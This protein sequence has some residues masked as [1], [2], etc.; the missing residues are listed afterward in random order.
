MEG[1]IKQIAKECM[2]CGSCM[3]GETRRTCAW[4]CIIP[5]I[6]PSTAQSSFVHRAGML[7]LIFESIEEKDIDIIFEKYL[8]AMLLS[9]LWT[10]DCLG[11]IFTVLYIAQ[12]RCS[13]RMHDAS[14]VEPRGEV[15]LNSSN[16]TNIFKHVPSNLFHP[17]DPTGVVK[18]T[19]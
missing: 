14:C 6:Y 10:N 5:N 17:L 3:H 7:N 15:I 16:L 18:C 4:H 11:I 1:L 13:C 19:R 9:S 8:A 12:R 2:A